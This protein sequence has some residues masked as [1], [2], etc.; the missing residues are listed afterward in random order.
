MKTDIATAV[1]TAILGAVI[2]FI[3]CNLF[4]GPIEDVTIKTVDAN[5]SADVIDPSPDVF[6]YRALNPTVEVYVGNCDQVDSNGE[7]I[8]QGT[9]SGD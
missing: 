7:C 2:A 5:I 3:V 8:N 4:I 6:N 9:E 1:G